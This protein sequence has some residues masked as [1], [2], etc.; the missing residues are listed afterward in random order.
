M[1]S[2]RRLIASSFYC[3]RFHEVG[4]NSGVSTRH[5]HRSAGKRDAAFAGA[6]R[7]SR[8][9]GLGAAVCFPRLIV[10]KKSFTRLVPI[11]IFACPLL[12]ATAVTVF[13]IALAYNQ[14]IALF[15]VGGRG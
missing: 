2:E 15:P 9:G 12:V 7:V 10:R 5:G 1:E 11:L 6:R 13:T 3:V 14:I 8:P 4:Q